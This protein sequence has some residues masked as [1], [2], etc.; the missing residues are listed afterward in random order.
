LVNEARRRGIALSK[1]ADWWS[2]DRK[3]YEG[4]GWDEQFVE[5][6]SSTWLSETGRAMVTRLIA[7]DRKKNIEWWIKILT[8]LLAAVISLMGLIVALV[9]VSRK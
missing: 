4:H 5:D 8:P 2:T 7:D 9:T 6:M 1:D 3:D